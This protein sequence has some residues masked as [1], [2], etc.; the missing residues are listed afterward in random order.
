MMTAKIRAALASRFEVRPV[1][2]RRAVFAAFPD[3]AGILAQYF[4][5]ELVRT[6]VSPQ[7]LD[8]YLVILKSER[9]FSQT[10]VRQEAGAIQPVKVRPR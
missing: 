8:A 3:R 7:G 4:R 9:Q 2:Y 5:P 6:E 1:T 10:N